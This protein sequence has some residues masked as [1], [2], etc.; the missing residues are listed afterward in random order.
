[1]APVKSAPNSRSP[2]ANAL[3]NKRATVPM[4]YEE[5]WQSLTKAASDIKSLVQLVRKASQKKKKDAPAQ[6]ETLRS[7]P[8]AVLEGIQEVEFDHVIEYGSETVSESSA[9][10]STNLDDM[11]QSG[12]IH[13]DDTCHSD[14]S[15]AT[16]GSHA[17]ANTFEGSAPDL[18]ALEKSSNDG[19]L[20]SFKRK[21]KTKSMK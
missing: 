3:M 2:S 16:P 1:M 7:Q 18:R 11:L 12:S 15:F 10:S 21:L 14:V 17:L 13:L 4:P 19:I 9:R 20:K 8:G 5:A 6:P